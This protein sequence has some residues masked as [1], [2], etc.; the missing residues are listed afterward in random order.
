MAGIA[1]ASAC[2]LAC[3]GGE[4]EDVQVTTSALVVNQANVFGFE[5]PAQWTSTVAV[6]SSTTH[7]QGAVSLA[8]AARNYVEVTSAALPS[9]TGVTAMIGMD[10]RLPS[11]QAE[12]ILVRLRPAAGVGPEQGGQQPVHRPGGADGQAAQSVLPGRLQPAAEPGRHAAS[13]RL[14]GLQGEDRH[15]RS[16]QRDGELPVRQP[17]LPRGRGRFGRSR[18]DEH[19]AALDVRQQRRPDQHPALRAHG[20][21]GVLRPERAARGDRRALRLLPALQRPDADRHRDRRLPPGRVSRAQHIA[22]RMAGQRADH[23]H[24][25]CDGRAP[26]LDGRLD[27][28]AGRRRDVARGP[29]AAQRRPRLD[30]Q[31][32]RKFA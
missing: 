5:D 30:A 31:R 28:A 8:V 14:L 1:M 10:V 29:G 11:P 27:Q 2:F 22:R 3:S 32:D 7:T 9:L 17:A 23:R 15:Q 20:Q 4:I 21:P 25:G 19:P 16:L 18:R 24:R 6:S 13:G 26:D 12:P